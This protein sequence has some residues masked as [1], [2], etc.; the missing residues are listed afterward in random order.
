MEVNWGSLGVTGDQWESLGLGWGDL[1]AYWRLLE[2]YGGSL[3]VSGVSGGSMGLR[4]LRGSNSSA[5]GVIGG[6]V[7]FSGAQW[8]LVGL[9]V[10]CIYTHS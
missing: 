9:S 3:G 1:G 2:F 8:D 7:G 10:Q 5:V 4:E 6:S